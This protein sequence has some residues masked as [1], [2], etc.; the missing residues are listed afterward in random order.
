VFGVVSLLVVVCPRAAA[1]D[2]S[3][4][5]TQY[6]H[7]A[8]T[9]PEGL[10]GSTR[11]IVQTPDGYLWLGTEF[12]LVR[13]DGVR[14]VPW[15][16]PLGQHFPSP[17]ILAL[18]ATR[19]G[20]LWIG[21]LEGLA[22]WKEDKL[23]QYP[24]IHGGVMA[25]TEDHEGTVWAGGSGKICA[26]R[27]ERVACQD[28]GAGAEIG[29]YYRYGSRNVESLYEDTDGRLWAGTESGLWRWK[30]GPPQLY[31][32]NPSDSQQTLV[33]GEPAT[34]VIF[35]SSSGL[36][37]VTDNK[38][39]GYDLPGMRPFGPS[40]LLR[41]RDGA[42]WIGTFD[43]GLLRVF[44]GTTTWFGLRNGLTGDLVTAFLEDREGTI[45]VGTTNGLDRFREPA[46]STISGHQGLSSPAW[47]VLAARDGS[48]WVGTFNGLDRWNRGQMTVY[49]AA[50][51]QS[52]KSSGEANGAAREILDAGLLDNNIGSL[53]ED[54]R[55]RLWVT[56][57]KGVVRF[58]NGR[59][60][61][62]SGVPG[63]SANAIFA[64][65]HEGVWISYPGHGLFHAV[66]N[67][68][69]ESV[70]WPWLKLGH[71]QRLSAV[72]PDPVH[73][74]L[75]LGFVDGGIAHFKD[76][77]IDKTLGAKDGLGAD[78]IWNLQVD[79]DGTL[80][81]ATQ[82]GLSRVKDGGI[83]TLNT[84]N[85]L[86]CDAV[87]GVMQDDASSFWLYAAC[88]LLHV[89]RTEM[90]AWAAD[91]KHK[92]RSTIFDG[93]DGV[94]L[95]ALLT[96]YAPVVTKSADGKLWFV[97]SDGTSVIDPRNLRFNKVS[98]P[99]HVEQITADGKTYAPTAGLMLP[100]RIRNLWIDYTALSLVAPEKVRFR[101]KLE[102]QD[103][104]W[105][106]VVNDRQVQYS[107]LAPGHYRFRVIASNN[108]GVWNQE[109]ASLDFAIAPAYYQTN[110][111]R[112]LC[113]A[114]FLA[115][116]WAAYQVRVR[117]LRRQE[118]KLRDVVETIPTFAWTALPDGSIDF[119]NRNWEKYS[120]LSTENTAGS[121]W[122]AAVHPEDLKR[123][124]EKWRASIT[125]GEPFEHEVR[126][127]RADGEYRWFLVRAVPLRDQRGKVLKWYGTSTD[128]EDRKQ[129]EQRF[130]DLLE[131]A[132]DAVVV[133]NREGKI[134]L[135]NTQMEKLFGY[136]R[137]E[138]LGNEIEM[139]IPERFRSKHPG[140]RR[141]FVADPRAR[142]MG[143][144]LELYGLHKEGREFPVEIS[145]SPLQ[146]E[147]GV[148]ISSTIRDI[149]DRKRAE[150]KIR[151]SE[152]ELRQLVD[153]I[154]QQ[155]YVFD[156]DWSPLF[157]NQREREYTGLTLEETKSKDIFAR[158]FH[159]ED[160]R[161][162][163]AV[164]ERALLESVPCELE[165][166][167][168]GKD[169][170]YRWFLIRDNP[171]RD[172]QG[173][174][175][176]WYGTRTDIEDRKRAEEAARKIENE[177]RDVIETIP[178]MAFTT[179]PDGSN[180]FANRRWREY[181]GLSA[182]DTAGSGWQFVVHPQDVE[183]HVDKWRASVA[184]AEPFED[185]ARF[186]RADGQYRW[187]LIRAVPLR[188][189]H[190]NILKWYGKLTDIE[191]RKRA[192]Q[193]LQ[194]SEAYLAE[195]QRLTH[196]GTW[197]YKPGG[198]A[199][200]WSEENFRIWGFDPQQSTPSLELMRQRMHPEDRDRAMEFGWRS[201][202]EKTDY[203]HEFRIEL[204]DGT[205]RYIHSVGHQVLNAS[206]EVIEVVGTHIDV[207]ER[208]YAEEA[209]RQAQAALAH[210]T[211]LT[212]MGE[213][214]A[215]IAHE[216][217][218]PL[219][220]IVSNGSACLRWLAGVSPNLEEAR[221]SAR[222]IVR[223]GKRA[224]E[225]IARVR[226]LARRA[227][228]PS[229]KLDINQTIREILALV[230]DEAKGKGV[231]VRTQFADDLAPVLGDRVQLQ[232]VVLNLIM[233]GIEAMSS[234]EG[235]P[236]ELVITTRNVEDEQVLV[237]IQ[238]SGTGL[239][240]QNLDKIFDAF[241]TTKP[242]GLG[243]GLSVSRSIVQKHGG[244]LWAAANDGPGTTFH[245][246]LPKSDEEPSIA[247]V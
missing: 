199:L 188:D 8:W 67:R 155:V 83:A 174:V 221:E 240:P 12:G 99:V 20:T 36:E 143:S 218:Q 70:T 170:Q 153:V 181:T 176:R 123:H 154:P 177:L 189:E 76:G 71:D 208:K 214:T 35:G 205:V 118:K 180:A 172:E 24:E 74:G 34:S 43:R 102:G 112:A 101:F 137:Q 229:G 185:E 98:P 119:A 39:E 81:A 32:P 142:A 164:R 194:R 94:R 238:D 62:V 111:F 15:S 138:V 122:E 11:A 219:S 121:G 222:R 227:G 209:L 1:L 124:T 184:T 135:V 182:E 2:P 38:V 49:R 246:T 106:E 141:G 166:R 21:T 16:P 48:I 64:D 25:L 96:N 108:S 196:T 116:L 211:R 146:T 203:A 149:T 226:A 178:V 192:E 162:L 69:V 193:A 242:A 243:L 241:Y 113:A 105:R 73:D 77:Q 167:I 79:G 29:Q 139:L 72:V 87:H 52:R 156:A 88:G 26:I 144:G 109:G 80:W 68:V 216:I 163:E 200:Y 215:S 158:K 22:S 93:S 136:R 50:P 157:A 57:L 152:E 140:L 5:L 54:P 37:Q 91:P 30:P 126:F 18:L 33:P 202:R 244:R 231:I 228:T 60:T 236:R 171:L 213:M 56:S 212:T 224:G 128:I 198:D 159:P 197:A 110:W 46:V 19:D 223:D 210:V 217:N 7:T 173:R 204:P 148:L 239:E 161:K 82:G 131:S 220:G 207:T 9:A 145:L 232:Q 59:F 186:R 31:S 134:V 84:K 115:L 165:A 133:V 104:D 127:R 61:S 237:T 233:N 41:D 86:P 132:P 183:R 206:G 225:V 175:L 14:F 125:N 75:W 107:N 151:Q 51:A 130:R 190:G 4:D 230:G 129:A 45:W 78:Q 150:E 53:F 17:N 66:D 55:G 47:S 195:S 160:L 247:A 147:E 63:G 58:E 117:Q 90:E 201:V 235:R 95:H 13:F 40:K 103:Q 89:D 168:R 23:I 120:G 27:R 3:L 92:V 169:G 28:T 42:L 10:K 85:G 187:F 114:A 100:P 234:V 44:H 6:T 179:L 245:F 65:Q 191:D 97:H